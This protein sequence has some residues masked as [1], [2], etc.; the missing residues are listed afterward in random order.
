MESYN[1][2]ELDPTD[3]IVSLVRIFNPSS[4]IFTPRGEFYSLS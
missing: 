4:E 2:K 3:Y 1:V